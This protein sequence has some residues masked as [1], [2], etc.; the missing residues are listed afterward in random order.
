MSAPYSLIRT[1][2]AMSVLL[3]VSQETALS[4]QT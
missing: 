4:Q 2:S 1:L 3:L